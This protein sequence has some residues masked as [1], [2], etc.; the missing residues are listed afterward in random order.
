MF[1]FSGQDHAHDNS[2]NQHLMSMILNTR[3]RRM[4][5]SPHVQRPKD[6]V[7]KEL[8]H[9]KR[10]ASVGIVTTV[11]RKGNYYDLWEAWK[12]FMEKQHLS[13]NPMLSGKNLVRQSHLS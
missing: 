10:D 6:P 13:T 3:A 1:V 12:G 7:G 11:G 9:D 8:M 2:F 5:H 4:R